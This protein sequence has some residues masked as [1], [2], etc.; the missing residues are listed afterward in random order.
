MRFLLLA[1]F[2]F[3][4][5]EKNDALTERTFFDMGQLGKS[6][7]SVSKETWVCYHP[8]TEFHNKVCVESE[9]PEGCYVTGDSHKF[10]WLLTPE[11]CLETK[12]KDLSEVCR[13]SGYIIND[14]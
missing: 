2:L 3:S 10:C 6:D 14:L 12:N 13:N 5:V 7:I 8:K 11:D 4:C 1:V 9:Y